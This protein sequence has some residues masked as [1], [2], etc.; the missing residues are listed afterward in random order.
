MTD[1]PSNPS[2]ANTDDP[3]V[4]AVRADRAAHAAAV[5]GDLHRLVE[6]YREIEERERARGRAIILPRTAPGAA[7]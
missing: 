7:A 4:A 1:L 3:I 6:Q 5:D 2:S